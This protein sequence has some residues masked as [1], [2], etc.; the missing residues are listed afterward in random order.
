[1][2]S[3]DCSIV[4]IPTTSNLPSPG[5]GGTPNGSG[6]TGTTAIGVAANGQAGADGQNPFAMLMSLLGGSTIEGQAGHGQAGHGQAGKGQQAGAAEL[7]DLLSGGVANDAQAAELVPNGKQNNLLNADGEAVLAQVIQQLED[8]RPLNAEMLEALDASGLIGPELMAQLQSPVP[9]PSLATLVTIEPGSNGPNPN[10]PRNPGNRTPLDADG[11][12]SVGAAGQP[13]AP[14]GEL[15]NSAGQI[16]SP[17]GQPAE[18]APQSGMSAQGQPAAMIGDGAPQPTIPVAAQDTNQSTNQNT[19][20]NAA[21][22]TAQM[23][24]QNAAQIASN[25]TSS[26]TAETD[27]LSQTSAS[28]VNT[29]PSDT[30]GLAEASVQHQVQPAIQPDQRRSIGGDAPTGFLASLAQGAG[31]EGPHGSSGG[32]ALTTLRAALQRGG[33]QPSSANNN[34][35]A[36]NSTSADAMFASDGSFNLQDFDIQIGGRPLEALGHSGAPKSVTVTSNGT[37]LPTHQL[38]LT[39]A[40]EA[41]AGT[42]R[43]EIRLDPPEMGRIDVKLEMQADGSIRS[44][45]TVERPETFDAL[46]RDARQ[47]ERLLTQSGLKLDEGG[48][49][50]SMGN[51]GSQQQRDLDSQLNDRQQGGATASSSLSER[52]G[53]ETSDD[54]GN[55]ALAQAG[56]SGDG[57]VDIRV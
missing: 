42:R 21:Q 27:I 24:A 51:D 23:T 28:A 32:D 25:A 33:E 29:S 54:L 2:H 17:A 30:A 11:T 16:I 6:T 43:F 18:T 53:D 40:T 34:A 56:K 52:S 22:T 45:M 14:L 44:M 15:A 13:A 1:L 47:L 31:A 50:L 8:G 26:P 39:V 48:L 20:Q 12:L 19:V 46:N 9:N 37:Q 5:T 7:A 57:A 38:A 10:S 3:R 55:Q 41:R 36:M 35:T 49:Q 4:L